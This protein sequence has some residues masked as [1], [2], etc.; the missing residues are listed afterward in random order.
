MDG[1]DYDISGISDD[2]DFTIIYKGK[3]PSENSNLESLLEIKTSKDQFIGKLRYF[4]KK[5]NELQHTNEIYIHDIFHTDV[6]QVFIDS[7][8]SKHIKIDQRN[9]YELLQLSKKYE[10]KEIQEKAQEFIQKRPDIKNSIDNFLRENLNIHND[11]DSIK[12]EII[13]QNL[14]V[15]LKNGYLERIPLQILIRILNSPKRNIQDHHS[16]FEFVIQKMKNC[17]E[18]DK[19]IIEILP[20]CLDYTKMSSEEIEELL[21]H[22][23]FSTTFKPKNDDELMKSILSQ[24]KEINQKDSNYEEKFSEIKKREKN[25]EN[26]FLDLKSKYE[27]QSVIIGNQEKMIQDLK[28]LN[29]KYEKSLKEIREKLDQQENAI[30]KFPTEIQSIE[31]K[32]KKIENEM[33]QIN[34]INN[35]IDK[36]NTL[37]QSHQSLINEI[38]KKNEEQIN[39]GIKIPLSNDNLFGVFNYLQTHSN[40]D[41]EVAITFS[42]NIYKDKMNFLLQINN[43]NENFQTKNES[44]PWLCFQFINHQLIP[45]NY[46]IRS[47]KTTIPDYY[48]PRSWILEGSNNN[49]NWIKLD[50][51]NDC[52]YL[53]GSNC[54]HT[55]SIQN[56]EKCKFIKIRLTCPSWGKYN[57][58]NR[59]IIASI[60]F[61]G[62]LIKL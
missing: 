32:Y 43:T 5:S 37:I 19:N 21:K 2:Q 3:D 62:E 4:K 48:H 40:I 13:S 24:L 59:L 29:E 12:E 16:L 36:Q 26:L 20:S 49:S 10:Y 11:S 25:N 57:D 50:E 41:S 7:I 28:A 9:C 46:T 39:K 42:S 33:S 23:K 18:K 55:F 30:S 15:C 17:D 58:N 38:Q 35:K 60:E 6:F 54:C 14:D 31:Q 44:N 56:Q 34:D 8:I 61:Y 45:T 51:Q 52:T 53:N 27:Q 1:I 47:V 22:E